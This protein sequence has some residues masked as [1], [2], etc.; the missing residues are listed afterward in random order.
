[1]AKPPAFQF[2]PADFKLDT[3][4]M[5]AEQV[6]AYI[7]LLCVAWKKGKLRNDP[8][9]LSAAAGVPRQRFVRSVWP[10]VSQ[11]WVSDGNGS[12]VNER[13]EVERR[14]Q[15]EWREKSAKGGRA[16]GKA[17]GKHP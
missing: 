7:R 2:Y 13:Q 15:I 17:K 14:K 12:L 16:S 8:A 11:H 10:A 4:E 1:M 6:G 3:D 9:A 5:T